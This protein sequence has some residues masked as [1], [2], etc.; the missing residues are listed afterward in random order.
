MASTPASAPAAWPAS[1]PP[2]GRNRGLVV[3]VAVLSV[4]LLVACA[5]LVGGVFL[6][7][8]VENKVSSPTT[9]APLSPVDDHRPVATPEPTESGA[10]AQQGPYASAYPAT[11]SS[12]LNRVCDDN[13]Y[14][15]QSPKRAGKAPHPVVLL[16]DDGSGLRFQNGTYYYDEG[17]SKR[18]EETWAAENPAKVQLVACLDRVST[19][20]TIR[21]CKFDDPKPLTLALLHAGWRLRVYE[22]ATGRKL[23][24]KAM[25]GDD[26]KCPY[27][28][29]AGPDKKI[30]AE[31]S[32]RAV[33]AALR[34]LVKR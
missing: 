11:K 8:S 31:V 15:P 33:L 19:G 14:Y 30:Y 10:P 27:V 32:D 34:N 18:V 7:R 25:A 20:S 1:P 21:R 2:P 26:Q 5:G 6:L 13:I 17:L 3:A 29:L 22:V 12:D 28:V 4:L 24:D 23:L 16:V 9:E